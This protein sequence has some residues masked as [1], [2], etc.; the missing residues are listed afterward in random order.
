MCIVKEDREH[1]IFFDLKTRRLLFVNYGYDT[2]Y[3]LIKADIVVK[4]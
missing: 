2:L 1:D 4:E 3:D